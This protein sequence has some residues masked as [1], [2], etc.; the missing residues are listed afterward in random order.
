MARPRKE[1]RTWAKGDQGIYVQF[2]ELPG[3]WFSS[4]Q[5]TE[6]DAINWARR[7]RGELLADKGMTLRQFATGFYD[8]SSPWVRRR[9]AKSAK[10]EAFSAEFLPQHRARLKNYLLPAFGDY[11]L[12]DITRRV[13]DDWLLDLKG[14]RGGQHGAESIKNSTKNKMID[15][16][17]HI[18]REAVDLGILKADPIAG[19]KPFGR[20]EDSREVFTAEELRAMFPVS[21][22]DAM[23]IW[24]SQMWLAYFIALR[25]T[26]LRPG[27]L[28][29][30]TWGD[31]MEQYGGFP[32]TK[33]IENRTG[34]VKGTKT[35]STKPAYLSTRGIQ[36][37]EIW[38]ANSEHTEGADYIFSFDGRTPML[39]ETAGKH[40]RGA[41]ARA[42]VERRRRTPYCLRHSFATFALDELPLELVQ[43]LL[44]HSTNSLVLLKS[45]YH[46]S[47]ENI[48]RSGLQ[49][50]DALDRT[51][52]RAV[53]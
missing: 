14:I 49:A 5:D 10:G 27:E 38:K 25:D 33:A 9:L 20:D 1:I 4:G 15:C 53:K 13:F 23:K 11:Q 21:R 41:L 28:H 42:G 36:E 46:P 8:D 43:K 22:L 47:A 24:L 2:A 19:I 45:Y 12:Q 39:T 34:R 26:G 16:M 37:L 48:M 6:T 29:A 7:K 31:W 51:D 35:G 32:V 18:M 17:K 30:L 50:K 52:I 44:G 3:R 40:F